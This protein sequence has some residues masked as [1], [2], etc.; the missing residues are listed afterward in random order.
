MNLDEELRAVLSQEADLR[1]TPRPDIEGMLSGG[2]DRLRRRNTMRIGLGAAA[3]LLLG[4]GLY[5]VSQI[6]D[7]D[8]DAEVGVTTVPSEPAAADPPSW[9][10]SNRGAV[11]PGTYRVLVG[12]D[13]DGNRIEADLTLGGTSWAGSN[14]PVAYAGERFAGVGVYQP[15]SVA[16]GCRMEAG[17]EPAADGPQQLAR[18]LARMPRSDVLQQPTATDAFGRTAVHLRS[19]VDAACNGGNAYQ[20]ADAPPGG[21]GISYFDDTPGASGFV[22]IDFW[23]V[24]VDGSTVVVDMF[25]TEDAPRSLVDDATAARESIRFVTAE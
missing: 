22:V 21:R 23:V 9:T 16:G 6:G 18:Q 1:T 7:G 4:G 25:R 19:R 12:A 10:D 2:Q 13:A 17:L 5:G 15:D 11:D 14:Y 3:V 24:D 20:V 8:A